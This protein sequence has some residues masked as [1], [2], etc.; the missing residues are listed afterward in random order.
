M[1]IYFLYRVINHYYHWIVFRQGDNVWTKKLYE[2]L[3]ASGQIY[4]VTATVKSQLVIRFVVCSRLTEE[5]DVEFAWNEIR[6]QAD[7]VMVD[8]TD[9]TAAA[10]TAVTDSAATDSGEESIASDASVADT[11]IDL[12]ADTLVAKNSVTEVWPNKKEHV[13]K[14]LTQG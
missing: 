3:M 12:I 2:R 10:D 7:R 13:V 5:S 9:A 1:N 4:M 11:I 6:A 8:A 14:S